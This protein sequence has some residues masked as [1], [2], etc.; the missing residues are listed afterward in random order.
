MTEEEFKRHL[1]S[2]GGGPRTED[3]IAQAER[4]YQA[5]ILEGRAE[6]AAA[7]FEARRA[8]G[9]P[10]LSR[11]AGLR[12]SAPS[13]ATDIAALPEVQDESGDEDG[14]AS[15]R[16]NGKAN[17]RSA[18][19]TNGDAPLDREILEALG[20]L[21]IEVKKQKGRA[22][23]WEEVE[24]ALMVNLH[25]LAPGWGTIKDIISLARS[26]DEY[27]NPVATTSARKQ[28]KTQQYRKALL[29]EEE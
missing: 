21:F 13:F 24:D 9:A 7:A 10:Q 2:V 3:Q 25:R 11:F 14:P 18:P 20:R 19:T 29:M 16:A 4:K 5:R 15:P 17:R 28:D 22:Q 6:L 1:E 26:L 23:A 12:A 8:P 27:S